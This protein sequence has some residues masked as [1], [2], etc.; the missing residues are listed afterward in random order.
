MDLI[1]K[2][3]YSQKSG[4]VVVKREAPLKDGISVDTITIESNDEPTE[5]LKLALQALADYV[6]RLCEFPPDWAEDIVVRGVTIK[7]EAGKDPGLTITALRRLTHSDTPLVINTP[8]GPVTGALSM[9]LDQLCAK[10]VAYAKGGMRA[11]R[12]LAFPAAQ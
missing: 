10:A 8:F 11:Q 4:A 2:F 9:V 3:S 5:E 1:L 7:P 12:E 6:C